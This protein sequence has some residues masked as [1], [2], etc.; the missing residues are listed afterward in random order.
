MAFI[1]DISYS[2]YL[3]HWP[4]YVIFKSYFKDNIYG[5]KY[6]KNFVQ[7]LNLAFIIGAL[8]SIVISTII[9]Y[10]YERPY[11]KFSPLPILILVIGLIGWSLVLTQPDLI[12]KKTNYS[13]KY[14]IYG[15]GL[16]HGDPSKNLCE[17]RNLKYSNLDIWYDIY[18]LRTFSI[19]N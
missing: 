12:M 15:A 19:F 8:L 4:V 18:F 1:G 3:V 13:K 2:L 17:L 9:Y 14:D 7:Y 10:A 5:R 11:L 16:Q 6:L